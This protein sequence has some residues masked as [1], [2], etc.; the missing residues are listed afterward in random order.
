MGALHP[1]LAENIAILQYG[2]LNIAILQYGILN[3]GILHPSDII[4]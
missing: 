1:E 4:I 2:I 3:I